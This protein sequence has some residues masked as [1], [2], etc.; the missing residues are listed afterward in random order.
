MAL[1]NFVAISAP[2]SRIGR[3]CRDARDQDFGEQHAGDLVAK[4]DVIA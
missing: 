2:P 4:G 1:M 3:A